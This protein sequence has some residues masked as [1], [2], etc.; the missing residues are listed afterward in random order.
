LEEF[1]IVFLNPLDSELHAVARPLFRA[2]LEQSGEI[3]QGLL[4]RNR[5]LEAAGYHAQ[6][7]VTP[8]HTLCFA[9]D[10]GIRKPIRYDGKTFLIG[11][12]GLEQPELLQAIEQSPEKFSANVLLRPVLEDFLLPTLCYVG[13]PSEIAYFAQA[14]TVYQK[15]AGRA[16]PVV[17]RF[18][19]TLIEPRQ[20]KLLERYS[21]GLPDIFI[22]PEKLRELVASRALPDSIMKSFDAAERHVEEGL[23]GIRAPLEQLDRTLLD[24]AENAGSKMRYQLQS[25]RDKAARAE[26][27]KNSELQH[28]ADELSTLLYPNK[29]LQEREVGAAYFL[30]KYGM[31]FVQQLKEKL[32][33]GC[34]DHQVI[35]LET[36][37]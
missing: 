3:N 36:R 21:L 17:P 4:E 7:N 33:A 34:P 14:E 2:A 29:E 30:L 37:I 35:R 8:S 1:G 31:G 10:D 6:V 12:Q 22:G 32:K 15:L 23:S 27:R 24:A 9:L 26:A 19:A 16:T 18:F 11:E 5:E 20:A 28:H 25:L 13:G